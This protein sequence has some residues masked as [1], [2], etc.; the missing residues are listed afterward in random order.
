MTAV[1]Q[2]R[3]IHTA[4]A[5]TARP[6]LVLSCDRT[7]VGMAFA[8]EGIVQQAGSKIFIWTGGER[9]K[10]SRAQFELIGDWSV[11]GNSRGIYG[12]GHGVDC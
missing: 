8:P 3:R 9:V 4:P 11:A 12:R 6:L 2:S 7:D 10:L 5:V 1:A